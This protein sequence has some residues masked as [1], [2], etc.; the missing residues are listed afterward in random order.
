[1]DDGFKVIKIFL[2]LNV[3]LLLLKKNKQEMTGIDYATI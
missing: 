3:T 2:Y 1:M